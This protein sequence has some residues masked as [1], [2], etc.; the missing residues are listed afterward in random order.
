VNTA[1]EALIIAGVG[2]A[3][4]GYA[5]AKIARALQSRRWLPV[6][7]TVVESSVEH[8]QSSSADGGSTRQF[9]ARVRYSYQAEG[10]TVTG[11]RLTFFDMSMRHR[12]PAAAEAHLEAMTRGGT[13]ALWR[14]PGLPDMAVHD[15]R[16]PV[17]WWL[18]LALGI[19]F[20]LGGA[21]P[22]LLGRVQ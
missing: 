13:I 5:G 18:A 3:V 6:T 17:G 22:I 20:T 21:V 1:K 2:L 8:L 10:R 12:S 14:H 19:V 11:D 9:Q 16:I 7:A 15:R 4:T